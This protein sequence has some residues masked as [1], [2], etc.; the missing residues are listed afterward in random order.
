MSAIFMATK[1]MKKAK[2]EEQTIT[3]ETAT[4]RSRPSNMNVNVEMPFNIDEIF[5]ADVDRFGQLKE[6]IKYI[7]DR[8][9]QQSSYINSVETK[10]TTKLMQIEK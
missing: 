10:M 5:Q 8:L 6:V 7:L 1:Q 4:I 2:F 3:N 9:E